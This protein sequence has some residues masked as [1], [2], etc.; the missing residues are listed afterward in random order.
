MQNLILAVNLIAVV[1][2]FMV[3]IL[4]IY[5]CVKFKITEL[6]FFITLQFILII[7]IIAVLIYR[8]GARFGLI[9]DN[10]YIYVIKRMMYL[11]LSATMSISYLFF[12]FIIKRKIHYA[13]WFLVIH[14]FV[15]CTILI[16]SKI[17]EIPE[18]RTPLWGYYVY[19]F[20][21]LGLFLMTFL[22]VL[23]K[24]KLAEDKRMRRMAN[25]FMVIGPLGMG[26]YY[27][28]EITGR[29]FSISN[30][31][32]GFSL[33][34]PVL[35]IFMNIAMIIYGFSFFTVKSLEYPGT[36]LAT[37][38]L[39]EKFP[40]SDR[41][42]EIIRHLIAGLSNREIGEK[43][44]ISEFTV[45]THVRNIYHKMDIKNRLELLE[46]IKDYKY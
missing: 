27:F 16:F 43:L 32:L 29:F 35:F 17:F 40:L 3:L 8:D 39:T 14:S 6:V 38:V 5:V 46:A 10:S 13:K 21:L 19:N 45:K 1:L 9:P 33:P 31:S 44:F 11:L 7:N 42:V 18:T 25:M 4:S 36:A 28:L 34:F 23:R 24:R 15:F 26:Y 22:H 2:G 37:P 20:I 41:E 30:P 12:Q